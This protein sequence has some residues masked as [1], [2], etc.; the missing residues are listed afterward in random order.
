MKIKDLVKHWDK[1]GRGRLTRDAAYLSLAKLLEEAACVKEELTSYLEDGD[2]ASRVDKD[3]SGRALV[4]LKQSGMS[5]AKS[6]SK[7]YPATQIGKVTELCDVIA[8]HVKV[9]APM[10]MSNSTKVVDDPVKLLNTLG[11]ELCQ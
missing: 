11:H 3:P 8:N 1:H 6:V 2:S 7:A 5:M 9:D 10:Y 4:A